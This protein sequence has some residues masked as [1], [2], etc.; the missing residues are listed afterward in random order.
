MIPMIPSIFPVSPWYPPF[1]PSDAVLLLQ[2]LLVEVE[3]RKASGRGFRG[4][5]IQENHGKTMGKCWLH[6]E[7]WGLFMTFP[8][9]E[10][11]ILKNS[12]SLAVCCWASMF[13]HF[14]TSPFNSF[15]VPSPRFSMVS[16]WT[17]GGNPWSAADGVPVICSPVMWCE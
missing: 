13:L 15:A 12:M 8:R 11:P 16:C 5:W 6:Q 4:G 2:T 1:P 7:I 9:L 17:M 10:W 3:A 14:F